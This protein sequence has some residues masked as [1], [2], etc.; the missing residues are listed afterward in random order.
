MSL[1]CWVSL[2][3]CSHVHGRSIPVFI[4]HHMVLL[5]LVLHPEA[6]CSSGRSALLCLRHGGATQDHHP[7]ESIGRGAK[8]GSAVRAV[9]GAL[10]AIRSNSWAQNSSAVV[11]SRIQMKPT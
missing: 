7:G 2:G 10:S 5:L 9:A 3:P 6:L 8:P 4:T 1:I 11:P